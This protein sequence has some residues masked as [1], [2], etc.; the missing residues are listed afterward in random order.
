LGL[1]LGIYSNGFYQGRGN[2]GGQPSNDI[3]AML[4]LSRVPSHILS[5]IMKSTCLGNNNNTNTTTTTT[6][7]TNNNNAN[8]TKE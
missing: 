2:R 3:F 1:A 5:E 8:H 6:T 7:T 4:W